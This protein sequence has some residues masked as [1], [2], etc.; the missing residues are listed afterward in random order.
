[1]EPSYVA[2]RSAG[3]TPGGMNANGSTPCGAIGIPIGV[4]SAV[5]TDSGWDRLAMGLVPAATAPCP[6]AN[7]VGG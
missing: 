4:L 7:Q 6:K 3:L 2:S 5:K 1:M